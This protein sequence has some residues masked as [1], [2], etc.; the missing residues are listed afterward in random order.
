MSMQTSSQQITIQ[1]R[2]K[3][4]FTDSLTFKDGKNSLSFL[5]VL[6]LQSTSTNC[7]C[8]EGCVSAVNYN[9]T[10]FKKVQQVKFIMS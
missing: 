5:S 9:T 4:A 7:S 8:A 2:K 3:I 10:K 1:T 6:A